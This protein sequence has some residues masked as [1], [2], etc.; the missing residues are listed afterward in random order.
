MTH[1]TNTQTAPINFRE[2]PVEIGNYTVEH[3]APQK[4]PH[5]GLPRE[6]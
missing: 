6:V 4:H 3:K 2:V 1:F 5:S